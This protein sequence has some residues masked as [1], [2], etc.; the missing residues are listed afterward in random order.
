MRLTQS[1]AIPR[2]P[3]VIPRIYTGVVF[4]AAG[5][6]QLTG[7]TTW[8]A[9][10]QSWPQALHEQLTSWLPHSAAWYA[11]FI[12]HTLLP[13]TDVIAPAL[14]WVHL[15][16]GIALIAGLWTRVTALIAGILLLNYA[17]AAGSALYG[18]ADSSAY[19]ALLIAVWLGRAG[20]TWGVDALLARRQPAMVLG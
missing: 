9:A 7:S 19:L 8:T 1:D 17:A 6:E 2:W 13:R 15:T 11:P 3:L 10:G 12:T 16:V 18:A 4:A 5:A 20:R 14:A